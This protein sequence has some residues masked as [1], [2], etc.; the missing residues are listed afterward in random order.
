MHWEIYSTHP[1]WG[2]MLGYARQ[3]WVVRLLQMFGRMDYEVI[4]GIK[5]E[6]VMKIS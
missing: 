4:D 2:C 5:P 6:G 1:Q 3:Q